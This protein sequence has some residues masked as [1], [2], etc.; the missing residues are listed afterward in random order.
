MTRYL[1][2][3]S[4]IGGLEHPEAAPVLVCEAD[5]HC[6]TSLARQYPHAEVW[7]DVRT[8]VPPAADMVVGGWPCQ[9]LSSAGK[10]GGLS[11]SRSG[12]FF[13]MLRVARESGAHTIVG[14]NVPNLLTIG[15]GSEFA[16][17][18]RSL[19]DAGFPNIAW[20]VLNARA[21]GLPQERRRLFI[22]ASKSPARA[23]ALHAEI[24]Q[25]SLD[26]PPRPLDIEAPPSRYAAGFYWTGGRR[27]V[28]FSP[29]YVPALKIGATD[30]KGRSPVAVYLNGRVRK[31]TARENLELQ[32]FSHID[33]S[34]MT[35]SAIL[36]MAG[37]AVPAPVGQFV[38]QSVADCAP[39]SGV[40]TAFGAIGQAGV[41]EDGLPWVIE[42]DDP[43][44]ASN[45]VDFLDP[46]DDNSL[47]AQAAAGLLVRSIRSGLPLPRE[48]FDTL[49]ELSHDRTGR[50]HPSR[51]NSFEA[52]DS[53][54]DELTA[55]SG[56]LNS[57]WEYRDKL[58]MHN[59]PSRKLPAAV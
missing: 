37:N 13:E 20:R 33:L 23:E 49:L 24:P 1:S 36:R 54:G 42:H 22:V 34:D 53:M 30:E 26:E 55:Y 10:L 40:R 17:V 31:L 5:Q 4:G 32:G 59:G 58:Q 52:L 18:L 2:L 29:G 38:V 14:E 19:G 6:R 11:G 51:G 28:C 21:F 15:Q 44:L 27:S 47:T 56:K 3:F 39:P 8:L 57:I 46:D 50:L 48:L 9:D 12:L 16:E 41:I 43:P 45:L 25:L 7:A 35:P